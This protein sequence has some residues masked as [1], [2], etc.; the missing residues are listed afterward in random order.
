MELSHNLI[1]GLAQEGFI[2]AETQYT[3]EWESQSWMFANNNGESIKIEKSAEYLKQEHLS[4]YFG[5]DFFIKEKSENE[6]LRKCILK[7]K[8]LWEWTVIKGTDIKI[9]QRD[10]MLDGAK[11]IFGESIV[12]KVYTRI[13][14]NETTIENN[15]IDGNYDT[16]LIIEFITGKIVKFTGGEWGDIS[17]IEIEKIS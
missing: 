14:D 8:G 6:I 16:D 4:V 1:N 11:A 17:N 7:I 2:L 13:Y 5:K 12:L 10:D 3:W 15:V 9:I